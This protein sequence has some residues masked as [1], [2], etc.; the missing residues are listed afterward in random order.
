MNGN[1]IIGEMALNDSSPIFDQDALSYKSTPPEAWTPLSGKRMNMRLWN[2]QLAILYD[3]RSK[4]I[5]T[6]QAAIRL[7]RDLDV[8]DVEFKNDIGV[9]CDPPGSGKTLAIGSLISFFDLPERR[10]DVPAGSVL[11]GMVACYAREPIVLNKCSMV[12]VPHNI[13]FQW[14]N[15]LNNIG[16]HEDI[17]FKVIHKISEH[18]EVEDH[19]RKRI[20]LD[21]II[22]D[23]FSGKY[24]VLLVSNIAYEAIINLRP[25]LPIRV[26]LQRMVIDEADSIKITNFVLMP[27]RFLWLVTATPD[28]FKANNNNTK[29]DRSCLKQLTHYMRLPYMGRN[30]FLQNLKSMH[31]AAKS[32]VFVHCDPEFVRL[33]LAL[34]EPTMI[35]MNNTNI[36]LLNNFVKKKLMSP[37]VR[38]QIETGRFISRPDGKWK[39][40]IKLYDRDIRIDE[41]RVQ[42]I[43]ENHIC[44]FTLKIIDQADI[45][46]LTCCNLNVS[47]RAL[48]FYKLKHNYPTA[49]C[50][51]CWIGNIYDIDLSGVQSMTIDEIYD[52]FDSISMFDNVVS[53]IKDHPDKRIIIWLTISTKD[54]MVDFLKQHDIM[55]HKLEGPHKRVK[56]IIAQFTRLEKRVLLVGEGQGQ[57]IDLPMVDVMI[58]LHTMHNNQFK[59]M[60]GRGQRPGRTNSLVVYHMQSQ[61]GS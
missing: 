49:K 19:K 54:S 24:R 43:N 5:N 12:V 9:L 46:K 59:Q 28:C 26:S 60:M 30:A 45:I 53:I 40:P 47:R 34:P 56:D 7:R 42:Y 4:E 22:D 55:A 14:K 27:S 51:L 44:P 29:E 11:R 13:L 18:V 37:H 36:N 31:D 38:I 1:V 33:N 20:L 15:M 25:D 39:S 32:H 2:H 50:P 52:C 57:G 6:M 58:F 41:D 48:A 61:N 23:T 8:L 10:D 21:D 3:L 17:D 16:M 35:Q